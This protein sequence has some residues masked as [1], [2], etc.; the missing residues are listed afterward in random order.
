MSALINVSYD[1]FPVKQNLPSRFMLWI[2]L[3]NSYAYFCIQLFKLSLSILSLLCSFC[4]VF[5]PLYSTCFLS[6]LIRTKKQCH[7]SNS[8]CDETALRSPKPFGFMIWFS[9]CN[10]ISRL[11]LKHL[12]EI[13][14]NYFCNQKPSNFRFAEAIPET[15]L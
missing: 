7:Q 3:S 5:C 4:S 15:R 13:L 11:N 2:N 12:I 14:Q 6:I 9:H 8:L 10:C 1:A